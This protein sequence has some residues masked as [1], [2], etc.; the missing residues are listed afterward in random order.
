MP[1]VTTAAPLRFWKYEGTANDF[2]IV[3]ADD[4]TVA[5][6]DRLVSRLCDRHRG[7][8]ADG[9]LVV[10]GPRNG[11]H[12]RMIVRNADGSQPEMCGNGLRCVALHVRALMRQEPPTRTLSIETDSGTKRC[13][14]DLVGLDAALVTVDMG[15][16]VVGRTHEIAFGGRTIRVTEADAGNP[17]AI[18]FD[19]LSELELD[20]L[21][22]SLQRSTLFPSGV[23]LER[24]TDR[25]HDGPPILDVAV[26]ERGVGRTLACGTGACAVAA[27]AVA[28]GI[29]RVHAPLSIAL[30]GGTLEITLVCRGHAFMRG[31][32]RRVF[33][34]VFPR[35][36]DGSA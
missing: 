31:A 17:H 14:V 12:A 35:S 33:S 21:G 18:T 20:T 19:A 32:A 26:F 34:G 8:G 13:D 36:I 6:D 30:P 16:I 10:G 11:A 5:L 25:A 27:V 2:V 9:V 22:A 1:F 4:L 29:G 23:N 7:V 3:E 28:R 24:V 15:K